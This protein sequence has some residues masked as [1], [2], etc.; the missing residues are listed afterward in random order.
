MC[1][2]DCCEHII[3]IHLKTYGMYNRFPLIINDAPPHPP[4]IINNPVGQKIFRGAYSLKGFGRAALKFLL[5]S[6]NIELKSR[7][8][9]LKFNLNS[10]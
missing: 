1:A 7:L 6:M 3:H 9:Q 10:F 8:S 2:R 4:V 5:K